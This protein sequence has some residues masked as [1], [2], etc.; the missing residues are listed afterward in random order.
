M[1]RLGE[2]IADP[3]RRLALAHAAHERA[4]DLSPAAVTGEW[5]KMIGAEPTA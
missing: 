4:R 5:L 3:E 2:L 1:T